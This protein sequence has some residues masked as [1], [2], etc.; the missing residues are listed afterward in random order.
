[1]AFGIGVGWIGGRIRGRIGRIG[2]VV[3]AALALSGC[4][5]HAFPVAQHFIYADGGTKVA[6]EAEVFVD[7]NGS[8]YPDDWCT[9]F[10]SR[11]Q[12]CAKWHGPRRWK[13]HSLLAET[14]RE[15]K[16]DA[17]DGPA[18]RA[19]IESDEQRQ[20]QEL[21]DFGRAKKRI[22]I[23]I[24]GY[25]NTVA[26]ADPPFDAIKA[27]L[28]LRPDD[29]VLR[30]YWDG[31]SAKGIFG[32][33]IWFN[34]VGYS[35]LA[36][37]RGLRRVLDQF[38]DKEIYLISHSRGA[39]VILSALGNPVY[40]KTFRDKTYQAIEPWGNAYKDLLSPPAPAAGRNNRLHIL[41][42]AAAVGRI[43]FCDVSEQERLDQGQ[44][45]RK[46]RPLP[47]VK[48]FR[49]TINTGDPVLRK[50]FGLASRLN[51]TSFG[52]DPE[53]GRAINE[54]NYGMMRQY[55]TDPPRLKHKFDGY[56]ADQTFARMLAD[57]GILRPG[58]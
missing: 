44:G 47:E 42:M 41:L 3:A 6:A 8:F 34:A 24:H 12:P 32:A 26:E 48:S 31:L 38:Q 54:E 33:K 46:L 17:Q 27:K 45:C 5:G 37:S 14:Y 2:L 16:G 51:P 28:D 20:L 29:G 40:A 30:F 19:H 50:F 58:Q 49:Y 1:M 18:F 53:V 35:Q 25:N 36:G 39:S 55:F 13:A 21:R 7:P 11:T 10:G 43:D 57:E 15:A 23:L 9:W 22:F 52:L 56:V 4:Y